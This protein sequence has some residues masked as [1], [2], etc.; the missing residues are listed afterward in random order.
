MLGIL[1]H[2]IPAIKLRRGRGTGEGLKSSL[3]IAG[4]RDVAAHWLTR[5]QSVEKQSPEDESMQMK[6]GGNSDGLAL[7]CNF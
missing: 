4:R 5:K 2:R 7:D 3:R 6:G 1:R